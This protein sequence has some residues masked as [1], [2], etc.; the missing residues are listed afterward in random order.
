[1]SFTHSCFHTSPQVAH[2]LTE[3]AEKEAEVAH[4]MAIHYAVH[5]TI[6]SN[7]VALDIFDDNL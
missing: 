4:K 5:D 1:M 7:G 2:F 3:L 6:R